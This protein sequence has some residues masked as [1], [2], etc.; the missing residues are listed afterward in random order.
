M[1]IGKH[2]RFGQVVSTRALG[3]QLPVIFL[4]GS[5]ATGKTQL[6][7]Q[8][9]AKFA[10]ESGIDLVNV[11]AAQVYRGMD[12]GT[13][14]LTKQEQ[15]TSPHQ[16]IDIRDPSE[17]YDASQFRDDAL[18]IIKTSHEQGR[19]PLF[20]GGSLFYFS[21][22][23]NG[24]SDLPGADE[25]TRAAIDEEA[26]KI[27]WGAM[28]EQLK[29]IDSDSAK[30]INGADQQRIQR[31][32]EIYRLTGLKPSVAM[33]QSKPKR[34][35]CPLLKFNITHPERSVLHHKIGLRFAQMLDNGLIEEVAGLK[36]RGDLHLELASMRCVGYRQ[37]WSYL[38]GE[39][40]RQGMI[41]K[42]CAATR[43]LAK[44]Q[45]TWLR[46]QRGQVWLDSTYPKNDQIIEQFLRA[47][48]PCLN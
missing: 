16:L 33:A 24:V 2:R 17:T 26:S 37:V 28:Y 4:A 31:A 11:D 42:S 36:A 25:K 23:E 20:V 12:I 43:Q 9:A 15:A 45:L 19:I 35:D 34:L 41:D 14:K 3:R 22:L 7:I 32:F 39:Y 13:A 21:A 40:D 47:R 48:V 30:R 38:Q 29:A 27:G 6:A 5:T 10:D 18:E 8:L 1:G 46:N 44:R